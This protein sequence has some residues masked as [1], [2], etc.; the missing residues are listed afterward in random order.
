MLA[1]EKVESSGYDLRG[2]AA[3]RGLWEPYDILK[4]LHSIR[5]ASWPCAES[6]VLPA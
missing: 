5:I 2:I 3:S 4:Q 6:L 1:K